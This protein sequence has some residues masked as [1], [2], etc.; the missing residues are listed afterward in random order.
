MFKPSDG[1]KGLTSQAFNMSAAP[2]SQPTVDTSQTLMQRVTGMN[3]TNELPNV[4]DISVNSSASIAGVDSQLDIANGLSADVDRIESQFETAVQD[5]QNVVLGALEQ[6]ADEMNIN[7][8]VA[9]ASII[10]SA[11]SGSFDVAGTLVSDM[12]FGGPA[13]KIA[14]AIT[15]LG[16]EFRKLP[17]EKQSELL[18]R[19][20]ANLNDTNNPN[21]PNRVPGTGELKY[22]FS[23]IKPEE[24]KGLLVPPE[25]H[26][27][28]KMI[29]DVKKSLEEDVTAPLAES[30]PVKTVMEGDTARNIENLTEGGMAV[31]TIV[32]TEVVKE[33]VE[34]VRTE[35]WASGE[36]LFDDRDVEADEPYDMMDAT[37]V[38]LHSGSLGETMVP[39]VETPVFDMDVV[40]VVKTT[41]ETAQVAVA[42][43]AAQASGAR[44]ENDMSNGPVNSGSAGSY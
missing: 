14:E 29:A 38:S 4:A 19:M 25:A 33:Y 16:G 44:F 24:L 43:P 10:P 18:D 35:D 30:D 41:V 12:A 28:G 3:F 42:A 21:N 9:A 15:E 37:E 6:A 39:T 5:V 2:S 22:D 27:E 34:V 20:Y 13:S 17:P 36:P 31:E 32:S 23:T 11:S 40:E 7:L 1:L 8:G 26:P